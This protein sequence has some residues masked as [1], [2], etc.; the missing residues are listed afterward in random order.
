MISDVIQRKDFESYVTF[1]VKAMSVEQHGAGLANTLD[2][3]KI[4]ILPL[5]ITIIVELVIALIMKLK[6]HIKLIVITNFITNIILQV[7]VYITILSY[8][9][10]L[11]FAILEA[12]ILIGEYLIYKIFMKHESNKKVLIYTLIANICT[13]LLTFVE[14]TI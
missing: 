5:I 10:L 9:N 8:N 13:A 4:I 6:Q 14:I 2:I 7:T 1:D 11:I 12:I 3:I